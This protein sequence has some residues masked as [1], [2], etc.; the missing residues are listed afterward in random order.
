MTEPATAEDIAAEFPGWNAWRGV[1]QL[2]YA[3]LVMSSPPVVL[4]GQDL[5]DLRDQIIRWRWLRTYEA[6]QHGVCENRM[7]T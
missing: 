4:H 5:V 3:R 2:W 1:N 7:S 6:E